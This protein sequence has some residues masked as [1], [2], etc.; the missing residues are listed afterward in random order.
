LATY[1]G[2]GLLDAVLRNTSLRHVIDL[3]GGDAQAVD[4]MSDTPALNDHGVP[5][6]RPS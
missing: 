4:I 5:P 6:G 1:D 2:A 3:S